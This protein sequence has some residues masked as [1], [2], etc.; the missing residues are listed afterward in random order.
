VRSTYDYFISLVQFLGYILLMRILANA[1]FFKNQKSHWARTICITNANYDGTLVFMV[2]SSIDQ[3]DKKYFQ[4]DTS[5]TEGK[6][7]KGFFRSLPPV[8]N[9]SRVVNKSSPTV[10][11]FLTS[12]PGAT[13]LFPTSKSIF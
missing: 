5:K 4:I 9:Y 7:L 6:G 8:L 11:N 13:V 2:I 12:F 10:I 3:I 1:N